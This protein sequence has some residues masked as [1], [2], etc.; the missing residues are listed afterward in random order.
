MYQFHIPHSSFLIPQPLC[1]LCLLSALCAPLEAQ[2]PYIAQVFDYTPA[3]GQFVNEMPEWEEGDDAEAMRQKAEDC[4]RDHNQITITL[5]SWGG[6]VIFGFDHEVKNILGQYD[7]KLL[8]NSFYQETDG[9]TSV[10]TGSAEPG[11]VMVS[12][13]AN[14]NGQP[15]DPWYELAGSMHSHPATQPG[16]TCTYYRTPADHEA[17]PDPANKYIK[18]TSY[19]RWTATGGETGYVKKLSFHKQDYYPRWI[20]ADSLTFTGTR[21]PDNN[22]DLS[23][24][25]TNLVLYCYD[26]GYADNQPNSFGG[27]KTDQSIAEHLRHPSEFKIDWATDSDGNPVQ[28]PGI[29]FVK[30]YTAVN[31]FNG[32][33][34][35]AS[36]EVTDAWDLH[37][38]DADGNPIPA[39]PT[40][41]P[42]DLDGDGRLTVSDITLL[43]NI[44]LNEN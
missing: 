27:D 31:Q 4:L 33:M 28:L 10:K 9:V 25:G 44:Y 41:H 2:N 20:A 24:N 26:W 12:Y 42:Y 7:F 19:I 40:P 11:I 32:W 21:L 30:V 16:Y 17:T 6:Y 3:P 8:G 29:H 38:L 1:A 34:G 15:D 22:L 36:T 43:I 14:A 18:D 23:G 5:G 37:L 39:E 13:D 35:E